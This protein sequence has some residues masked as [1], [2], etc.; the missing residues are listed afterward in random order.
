MKITC[1]VFVAALT[2][3][4]FN[5]MLSAVLHQSLPSRQ[6]NKEYFEFQAQ[7]QKLLA[8]DK[9]AAKKNLTGSH[10]KQKK[11]L[12]KDQG[13]FY[14]TRPLISSSSSIQRE[15]SS[16]AKESSQLTS[17]SQKIETGPNREKELAAEKAALE[18]RRRLRALELAEESEFATKPK[19]VQFPSPAD[20]IGRSTPQY[21]ESGSDP[22]N[23]SALDRQYTAYQKLHEG[24]RALELSEASRL[25]KNKISEQSEP[26]L[27][28][29]GDEIARSVVQPALVPSVVSVT[30]KNP[31]KKSK[32]LNSTTQTA[33]IILP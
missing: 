30:L 16:G 8:E 31:T 6:F 26:D 29:N 4:V 10:N 14:Q 25:A 32:K 12:P 9:E 3:F 18:L 19:S 1:K 2:I 27:R 5:Q 11:K 21:V 7:R 22:D 13:L 24:L 20:S 28:F 15:K 23:T 17:I 33:A